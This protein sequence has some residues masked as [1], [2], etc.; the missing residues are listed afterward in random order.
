MTVEKVSFSFGENWSDFIRD[1]SEEEVRRAE[2]DI[3]EWL[4]ADAVAGKDVIDVGSG[5]GIHSLAYVNLGA[6]RVRSFDYDPLS[7]EATKKLWASVGEPANWT[8]EHG[9]ILDEDFVE[10]LGT[11]DIVYSWGVLHHTGAMWQ[12]IENA[13]SLVKPDG[14]LWIA[15]YQKGPRY[16]KDLEL[17]RRYNAASDFGKRVMVTRRI[18]RIMLSRLRHCRN[19]FAWNEASPRGMNRYHDLI[20]WLGGLPYEVATEDEIVT[21]AAQHGF[22]LKRIKV[23][24]E[25]GCS[26]YVFRRRTAAHR[27]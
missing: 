11:Y 26:K 7:V 19:P 3:R 6:R 24:P 12:A 14:M 8:V 23:A 15:I 21:S 5:S 1:V 13:Y 17:K 20:D 16:P 27:H 25:G 10:Q 9:S 18:L 22:V 4:G 2:D